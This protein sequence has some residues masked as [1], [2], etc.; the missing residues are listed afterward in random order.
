MMSL[1]FTLL[2]ASTGTSSTAAA[3]PAELTP[4]DQAIVRNLFDAGI[5]A[6]QAGRYLVAIDAFEAAYRSSDRPPIIFALAQALRLQYFVDRDPAKLHRAIALYSAFLQKT[7]SGAARQHAASHLE[8]LE[9]VRLSLPKAEPSSPLSPAVP[10]K[11]AV[12][13][14]C[15]VAG[16]R[17]SVEGSEEAESPAVFEVTPGWHKLRVHAPKYA[18]S[19]SRIRALEGRTVI[20]H[21]DL[22]PLPASLEIEAPPG[23]A[24]MIDGL[25]AGTA[26]MVKA[27]PARGGD[28]RI[29]VV[30]KGYYPFAEDVRLEHG[31]E[32]R[33]KVE[34][35][36]TTQS[37][38]AIGLGAAGGVLAAG[39]VISGV[40]ALGPENE[41]QKIEARGMVGALERSD[42]DRHRELV[43]VRDD[44]VVR[45]ALLGGGAALLVLSAVLLY[46]FDDPSSYDSSDRSDAL[47]SARF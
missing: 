8:T 39:S 4:R 47:P 36:R 30:S 25:R 46:F 34:L 26:P 10:P 22:S 16:A 7:T 9:R 40:S 21:V 1:I 44:R 28:H 31:E 19:E 43:E 45:T 17:I 37:W 5:R 6:Y 18:P 2:L 41:A 35:E 15:R 20:E 42:V 33:V 29:L 13:I 14:T 3:A 32:L 11:T 23:A 24:I 12:I 38:I 27:L